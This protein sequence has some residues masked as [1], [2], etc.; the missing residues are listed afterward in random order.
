MNSPRFSPRLTR[1]LLC[2]WLTLFPVLAQTFTLESFTVDGGGGTST[3]GTYT[4]SG[5]I[6]QPDAGALSGGNFTVEG[7]FWAVVSETV[8]PGS[9][10]LTIRVLSH[11]DVQV[12][13]P[14][15]SIGYALQEAL[16]ISPSPG[17]PRHSR[18]LLPGQ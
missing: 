8:V 5:T 16:S 2:L 1:S 10:E 17:C 12:C 14:T 15:S 4:L 7:G 13:W 18:R 9:P 3:G 6:G 11:G